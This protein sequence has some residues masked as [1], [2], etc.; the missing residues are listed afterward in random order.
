MPAYQGQLDGLCGQYAIANAFELCGL[1]SNRQAIFEAACS[2]APE[3]KWPVALWKGTTFT[4][5]RRMVRQCVRHPANTT[6]VEAHFP[7]LKSAPIS[8]AA[9]WRGFDD[10][11]SDPRSVCAIV[12]LSSPYNHWIVA[13]PDGGRIAFVD[14]AAERNFFRK[15]RASLYAGHRPRSPSQWVLDRQAVAIFSR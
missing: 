4:D 3:L 8:D 1:R 12:G 7:F 11:F 14:S 10:A 15:N 2:V 5:L 6:G 9:F 13:V